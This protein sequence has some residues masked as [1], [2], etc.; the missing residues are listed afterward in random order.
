MKYADSGTSIVFCQYW[1]YHLLIGVPVALTL[2]LPH[3]CTS[4]ISWFIIKSINTYINVLDFLELIL[5]ILGQLVCAFYGAPL[6]GQ[7]LWN[8]PCCCHGSNKQQDKVVLM[9]CEKNEDL[10]NVYFSVFLSTWLLQ[11][12]VLY[13]V[14]FLCLYGKCYVCLHVTN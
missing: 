1:S 4:F 6:A 3:S 12:S 2:S 13:S 7:V 10:N 9:D 14:L 5:Q 11:H 8:I